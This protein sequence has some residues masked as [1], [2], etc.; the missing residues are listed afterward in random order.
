MD[1]L[2][3]IKLRVRALA[4]A[5][6]ETMSREI[7]E[8]GSYRPVL[9]EFGPNRTLRVHPRY[10]EV[11]GGIQELPEANFD[12]EHFSQFIAGLHGLV[13]GNASHVTL[14]HQNGP[15]TFEA[16][17][18]V[19][20]AVVVKIVACGSRERFRLPFEEA[21]LLVEKYE[22]AVAGILQLTAK[23]SDNLNESERPGP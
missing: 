19:G 18:D 3:K 13:E 14:A 6:R 22:G 23:Q 8:F 7:A 11:L 9:I 16:R 1:L 15:F 12:R 17:I 2:A 10:V 5:V 4:F 20:G 21:S